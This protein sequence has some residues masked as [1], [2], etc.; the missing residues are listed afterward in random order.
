MACS[1][2]GNKLVAVIFDPG[3]GSGA[4]YTLQLPLPPPP[5]LPLPVLRITSPAVGVVVSWLIPSSPFMLQ[6]SSDLDHTNWTDVTMPPTLNFTNLHHEL[7][8]SVSPRGRFFR[9]KKQ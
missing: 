9:L 1:A 7:G 2:D 3:D 5:P 6:Q 8:V 4:I